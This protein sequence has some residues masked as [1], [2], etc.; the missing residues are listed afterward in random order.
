MSV[1]GKE[2]IMC[3]FWFWQDT[4]YHGYN[5]LSASEFCKGYDDSDI[6]A[7]TVISLVSAL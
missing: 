6:M 7:D 3:D 2:E 1:S 5:L 4:T